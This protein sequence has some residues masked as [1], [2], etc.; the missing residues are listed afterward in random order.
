MEVVQVIPPV[1][2]ALWLSVQ[3]LVART[4]RRGGVPGWR[5]SLAGTL[6]GGAAVLGIGSLRLFLHRGTSW[7]PERPHEASL[8]VTDGPNAASRNPM[9]LAQVVGLVAT[10]LVT[11]RPWTALA[12]IGL[13]ATL[14]PQVVREE[15]ALASL[16]GTDYENYRER[17]RR[18]L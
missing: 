2:T 17:V 3:Q 9:Y 1:Q 18:W 5:L 10:G 16:F 15:R 6:L 4:G 8:L 13:A 12:G 14:T 11:P 7:H